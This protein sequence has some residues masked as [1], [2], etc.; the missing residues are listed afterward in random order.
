MLKN[1]NAQKEY[2]LPD[3]L[4][5]I[6]S[7][8]GKVNAMVVDDADEFAGVNSR[9]QLAEA[10]AVMRNRINRYHMENGVTIID[11][12]R[13]YIDADAVIGCDT[14]LLPGVVIE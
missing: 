5:I 14:V 3:T 9:V 10:E 6:L 12:S 8:G 4:E 11:P 7:N 2:Y 1:D 13:T